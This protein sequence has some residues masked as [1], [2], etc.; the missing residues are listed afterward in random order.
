[1][2]SSFRESL[3]HLVSD[4]RISP[5]VLDLAGEQA[6]LFPGSLQALRNRIVPLVAASITG[7]CPERQTA[8]DCSA[9]AA[10]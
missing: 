7:P 4:L 2:S 8:A 9:A 10:V 1:M 3:G 6:V 5:E